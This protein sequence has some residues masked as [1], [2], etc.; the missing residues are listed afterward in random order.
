M[1]CSRAEG[2]GFSIHFIMPIP[3]AGSL[4]TSPGSIDGE[5]RSRH[6]IPK[7]LADYEIFDQ[8]VYSP[9]D[10]QVVAAR[11]DLPDNPPPLV[12][13]GNPEGNHVIL[14]CSAAWVLLA[15]M[16]QGS[17]IPRRHDHVATG[18]PL[19][20]VGNS[21]NSSEPHLHIQAVHVNGPED[22]LTG[23]ALPVLFDGVFPVTNRIIRQ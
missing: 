1:P 20:R 2:V 5:A 11:D 6:I 4:W 19:G 3:Q 17:L 7:N 22:R 16:K 21:G 23:R 12:D 14:R 18:Q 8:I 15:H 10:G 9:C 13:I